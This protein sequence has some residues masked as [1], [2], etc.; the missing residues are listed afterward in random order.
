MSIYNH[1][2]IQLSLTN[3]LLY[4]VNTSKHTLIMMIQGTFNYWKKVFLDVNVNSNI[5]VST[6]ITFYNYM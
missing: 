4:T 5:F 3:T 1:I 2:P 6:N